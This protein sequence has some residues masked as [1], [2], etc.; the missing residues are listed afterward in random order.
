MLLNLVNSRGFRQ[1]VWLLQ[2]GYR[3]ITDAANDGLS[4]LNDLNTAVDEAYES[5]QL[6]N[7]P[8]ETLGTVLKVCN[9]D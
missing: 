7:L 6:E 2:V 3:P 5:G 9:S 1:Q 8:A 4:D